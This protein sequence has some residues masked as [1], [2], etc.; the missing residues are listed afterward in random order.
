[1]G[2]L[3]AIFTVV[4]VELDV[5]VQ[6]SLIIQ[7]VVFVLILQKSQLC[8]RLWLICSLVSNSRLSTVS[9]CNVI[10][11]EKTIQTSI[12]IGSFVNIT[13]YSFFIHKKM[14]EM[15]QMFATGQDYRF[16]HSHFYTFKGNPEVYGLIFCKGKNEGNFNGNQKLNGKCIY[17]IKYYF[18]VF[19][20]SC[21]ISRAARLV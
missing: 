16:I 5:I 20:D 14:T 10:E 11:W 8:S 1:M 7:Q 3:S 13:C 21:P 4:K 9:N 19:S 2:N 15:Q 18:N 12:L 17:V 6:K